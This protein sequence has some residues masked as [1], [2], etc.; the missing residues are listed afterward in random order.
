[1]S[2]KNFISTLETETEL[3]PREIF[4]ALATDA[5]LLELDSQLPQLSDEERQRILDAAQTAARAVLKLAQ[6]PNDWISFLEA[7]RFDYESK[8]RE[9]LFYFLYDLM[10]PMDMASVDSRQQKA[11]ADVRKLVAPANYGHLHEALTD[12]ESANW[13]AVSEATEAGFILGFQV[14]RDP[15]PILFEKVMAKRISEME[16]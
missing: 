3:S 14:A 7:M 13:G 11:M 15:R 8:L 9:E 1:M 12:L 16:S 5:A 6:V 10:P 4:S 2:S